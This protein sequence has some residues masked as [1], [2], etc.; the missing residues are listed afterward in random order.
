MA[1]H[2]NAVSDAC[3]GINV[4]STCNAGGSSS[5]HTRLNA[6]ARFMQPLKCEAPNLKTSQRFLQ[7]ASNTQH[8]QALARQAHRSTTRAPLQPH[9][10]FLHAAPCHTLH[11]HL[12]PAPRHAGH[13]R[14]GRRGGQSLARERDTGDHEAHSPT[15]R[16]FRDNA[17]EGRQRWL[18]TVLAERR[19]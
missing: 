15:R 1:K 19:S 9:L 12:S 17:A 18:P 6:A 8:T 14:I 11:H 4:A 16:T 5:L 2:R 7:H 10:H 3:R 13:V